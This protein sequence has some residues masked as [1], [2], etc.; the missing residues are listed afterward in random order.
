MR[1]V[2][3]A[4]LAALLGACSDM[5]PEKTRLAEARAA[6]QQWA[7]TLLDAT[8]RGLALAGP[9]NDIDC[10]TETGVNA[11]QCNAFVAQ[12]EKEALKL[13]AEEWPKALAE[14]SPAI[15]ALAQASV[16][17]SDADFAVFQ[18]NIKPPLRPKMFKPLTK[19]GAQT[20]DAAQFALHQALTPIDSRLGDQTSDLV[21]KVILELAADPALQTP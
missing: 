20:I 10:S 9:L 6:A 1:V 16:K 5:T 14:V 15:E 7:E 12:M 2:G 21:E 19:N 8:F 4:L 17:L 3:I 13:R 11:K 18:E